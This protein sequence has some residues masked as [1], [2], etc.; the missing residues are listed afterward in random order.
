MGD[1][2]NSGFRW[3]TSVQNYEDFQNELDNTAYGIGCLKELFIEFRKFESSSNNYLLSFINGMDRKFKGNVCLKTPANSGVITQVYQNS[4]KLFTQYAQSRK[5]FEIKFMSDIESSLNGALDNLNAEKEKLNTQVKQTTSKI[6]AI[7]KERDKVEKKLAIATKDYTNAV[8]KNRGKFFSKRDSRQNDI[9]EKKAVMDLWKSKLNTANRTFNT[10]MESHSD[11][12]IPQMISKQEALYD[13]TMKKI[14][15][16]VSLIS[17]AMDAYGTNIINSKPMITQDLDQI[18]NITSREAV[19]NHYAKETNSKLSSLFS[20][21]T[22]IGRTNSSSGVSCEFND[23]FNDD[24]DDDI[25]ES[26][27]NEDTYLQTG[28]HNE[29]Q[30]STTPASEE[31]N[32]NQPANESVTESASQ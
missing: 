20:A 10:K 1:S 14:Q 2:G 31:T 22:V 5:Q 7:K 21:Q 32:V 23:D 18:T 6:S 28:E 15:N 3:N 11:A 29:C 12:M 30:T 13:E 17:E 24:N 25:Y 26:I 16:F 27:Y 8:N 19:L 4:M 9:D